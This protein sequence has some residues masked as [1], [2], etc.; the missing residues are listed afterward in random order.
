MHIKFYATNKTKHLGTYSK[1]TQHLTD[2]NPKKFRIKKLLPTIVTNWILT[3]MIVGHSQC[4]CQKGIYTF[5]VPLPTVATRKGYMFTSCSLTTIHVH[6]PLL[7]RD[8]NPF[9]VASNW[10]FWSY[11]PIKDDKHDKHSGLMGEV[12]SQH[13]MTTSKT[14]GHFQGNKAME[15]DAKL[16][17]KSLCHN[18]ACNFVGVS[19]ITNPTASNRIFKPGPI[20]CTNYGSIAPDY[21][22]CQESVELYLAPTRGPQNHETWRFY[23]PKYGL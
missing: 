21:W 4:Q 17:T 5:C 16:I 18:F 11:H 7:S 13:M 14:L 1:S 22:E 2:W 3:I 15:T 10:W 23:T 9:F 8:S 20:R 6:L 12:S 19:A